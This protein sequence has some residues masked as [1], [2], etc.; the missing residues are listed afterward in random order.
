MG[1]D[2]GA[3]SNLGAE[4]KK[5][6]KFN[7]GESFLKSNACL[8]N[9]CTVIPWAVCTCLG[10]RRARLWDWPAPSPRAGAFRHYTNGEAFRCF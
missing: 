1:T 7:P 2:L 9:K 6:T 4:A 5:Q 3:A 8:T 10:V